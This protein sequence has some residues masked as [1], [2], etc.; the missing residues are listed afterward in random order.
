[1]Q[2]FSAIRPAVRRPFQEN[3]WGGGAPTPLHW[4]GLTFDRLGGRIRPPRFFLNNVRTVT[5]IDPK[6]GIPL[7]ISILRTYTKLWKIL[8]EICLIMPVEVT[9]CHAIFWSKIDKC[10]KNHQKQRY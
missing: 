3:S 8:W 10:L 5:A 1:M 4:R 6:L 7:C 9:Q 2:N